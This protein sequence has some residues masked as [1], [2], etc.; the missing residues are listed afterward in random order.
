MTHFVGFD[1]ED[2]DVFSV[3]GL[4]SRMDALKSHLRPK[5]EQL[6]EDFSALLGD[7][8]HQ[9]IYAHVAKHARRTVNPPNDSWVAFCTDKRGYKKHPHFQIGAWES[10]AF[11]LFGLIYESPVRGN[12]AAKLRENAAAV[13]SRIP[14]DFVWVPNHM[15]P[16]AISARDV[17]VDKLCELADGLLKKRQGELLVGITLPRQEAVTMTGEAF[18]ARVS[19]CFQTLLP[20]FELAQ[21]EELGVTL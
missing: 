21:T 7:W 18:V 15:D 10:H 4:E 3:P 20:L 2:F 13:V 9:P 16:N 12:Y 5:L 17:D 6:G 1:D 14:K 19:D 8:L 11:A